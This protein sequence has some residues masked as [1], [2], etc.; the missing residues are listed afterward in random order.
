MDVR[1]SLKPV[2]IGWVAPLRLLPHLC[3][4]L[5]FGCFFFGDLQRFGGFLGGYGIYAV[6][7]ILFVVYMSMKVNY[8]NSK[9]TFFDDRLVINAGFLTSNKVTIKFMI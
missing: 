4:Y 3:F 7:A 1:L 8:K 5:I 6:L 2:F 9:Y